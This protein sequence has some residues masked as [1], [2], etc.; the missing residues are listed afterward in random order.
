[1]TTEVSTRRPSRASRRTGIAYLGIIATGIFAEFAVRSSLVVD[2]DPIETAANI[3]DSPGLF[4][5]AISADVMMIGFDV[6]VALGL[7]GLLRHVD[8]RLA[9]T[10]TALRLIQ[11]AVIAVNL[12]NLT[13][14]LDAAD[15][16]VRSDGTV[17][18][19]AAREALDAVEAHAVGY[20]IGLIA[21]AF[22]CIVIARLLAVGGLASRFFVW[23]MAATGAVYL[24]GSSVAVLA[25]DRSALVDPLYVI[26]LVVE[27]AFAVLLITRGLS[28]TSDTTRPQPVATPA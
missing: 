17:I 13:D 7:L 28:N 10:A 5:L 4:R 16:A 24:I 23:G 20:D 26:P 12:L 22:S 19:A 9:I 1:M 25:P 18:P 11:G 8:R 6:V 2:D 21:F 3:A 27:L 14:A 15:R